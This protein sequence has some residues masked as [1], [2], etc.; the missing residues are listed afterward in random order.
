[1]GQQFLI[2]GA[3]GDRDY[4]FPAF[5]KIADALR[6]E[7][8][9]VALFNAFGFAAAPT[10]PAEK[11][12]E[13]LVTLPG[14]CL[15]L[16]KRRLRAALPW[17]PDGRRERALIEAVRST[18]PDTLIVIRGFPHREATLRQC[19]A[20]GVETIV[21]WY[22]EG[23]LERGLAEAESRR[24]DRC[25][26]IHTEIDP[27]YRDRIGWLPSYGLDTD[28]FYRRRWPRRPED[29]I[30]FVGTPTPRRVR[31]LQ[32]LA[33]LPL[34]LWGPKWS[35]VPELARFHRGEFVWGRA[36]NDLYN[37]SAIVLN[38]SSWDGHLSG[39]T[40]RILE[41]PASGAL[42]L[43][44]DSLEARR[45]FRPGHEMDVFC[46]P[47]EL[48]Q[49]CERHLADGLRRERIAHRGHRRA[50]Q[51]GDFTRTARVLAGL[52][53]APTIAAMRDGVCAWSPRPQV[54][55]TS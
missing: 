15:G 20:L 2:S 28:T 5:A 6:R 35:Q 43:T 51:H 22:V 32:A 55:A 33:P 11:M 46:S 37:D 52:V 54:L 19:R 4:Q 8:A 13:R 34:A 26:C 31:F 49:L 44:D 18:R 53:E 50:L 3:F 9:Q 14:R 7:G 16:D 29:R 27:D 25:F 40:Q 42:M 12:L 17:T 41:I 47:A 45:L 36:L 24:Y 23:P 1:M 10:R 38:L 48:R 21:G 39:M 30:V